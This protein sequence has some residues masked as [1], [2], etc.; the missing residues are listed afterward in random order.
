MVVVHPPSVASGPDTELSMVA[1]THTSWVVK[2]EGG[3]MYLPG[4]QVSHV[5][6][7]ISSVNLPAGQSLQQEA[8]AAT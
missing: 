5:V 4:P 7:E 3:P 6:F 2:F 8:P 1:M